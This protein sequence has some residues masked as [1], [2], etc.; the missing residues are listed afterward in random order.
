MLLYSHVALLISLDTAEG[1]EADDVSHHLGLAQTQV[2]RIETVSLSPEGTR[3]TQV[4]RIWQL[5]SPKDATCA[6][7]DRLVALLDK[8]EPHT[9]QVRALDPKHRPWLDLLFHVTPQHSSGITGE[10]GLFMMS[11][12][13]VSRVAAL[14]LSISHETIWY[15]HPDW[16]L[17]WYRR[18]LRRLPGSAIHP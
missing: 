4:S 1:P 17:P 14:D 9:Q 3:K 8:I 5:D 2:R 11:R 16:G 6:A 15:D 18:L 13:V 10:F 12:D 7:H